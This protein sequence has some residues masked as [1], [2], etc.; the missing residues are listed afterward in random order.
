MPILKWLPKYNVKEW[1][2]G[3]LTAGITVGV[4]LIPQSMAYA[5]VAGLPPIYG[6]YS[7][8]VPLLV[9][10]MYDNLL[11]FYCCI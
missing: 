9:F 7:S 2:K 10:G 11:P 8:F 4:M 6:I 1:L 3:D 5:L